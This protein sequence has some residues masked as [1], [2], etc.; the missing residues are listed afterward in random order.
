MGDD[1]LFKY[2]VALSFA[3][4]NRETVASIAG[5]LQGRGVKVFY[6]DF[7]RT[8][9]WGKDLQE[10]LVNIYMRWARYAII[11]VSVHYKD[12]IWTRHELKSVLARAIRER[13]EYVLPV[14]FDD[15][16][17]DGLL[18]TIGYLDLRRETPAEV[19]IRICQ[20][21][22]VGASGRKA[23]Q[24]LPPWSPLEK[25]TVKFDY[26]SH[27]GRYRIGKEPYLFETAWSKASDVGFIA[28]MTHHRSAASQLR[29][30]ERAYPKFA[31]LEPWII[32]RGHARP[33]K[34]RLS[35]SKTPTDFS[36]PCGLST[37]RTTRGQTTK[38]NFPSNIG[39]Y[40]M[41]ARISQTSE[42][43]NGTMERSGCARRL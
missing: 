28:T 31:T 6:D 35:F 11:F 22:G 38:T 19:C 17:L 42:Q 5:C 8:S 36:R 23:D 43:S 4:E 27:N 37:S 10:H 41:A 26:S 14:R 12:K 20:K 29:P 16:P 34:H 24:V 33:E 39:S 7:E 13:Q 30:S 15:T 3:G 21:L 9:L 2:D 32:R 40:A 25:G 18:P 1:P